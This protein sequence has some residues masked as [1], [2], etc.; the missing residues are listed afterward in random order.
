MN[1][2]WCNKELEETK[3]S[4]LCSDCQYV[5][6]GTPGLSQEELDT[7]PFGVIQLNRRGEIISFN[8]AERRLSRRSTDVVGKNF[9]TDIAP[10]ADVQE[11]KGRFENFLDGDDLS[12]T[13][14]YTYY[15][16]SYAVEVQ[17]TFLRVNREIAFVLSKRR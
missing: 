13:F 14:N 4:N 9:F 8:E 1:C 12:E 3:R 17:L 16:G 2:L 5:S 10:C 7:L 6:T 15:F 11:Y